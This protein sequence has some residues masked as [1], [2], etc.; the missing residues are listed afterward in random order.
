[1]LEK[2]NR[3]RS[4][5]HE[6]KIRTTRTQDDK[7][8]SK[9]GPKRRQKKNGVRGTKTI[10]ATK[11]KIRATR[12]DGI[13]VEEKERR[14]QKKVLKEIMKR[15]NDGH[16]RQ[17]IKS[18][19]QPRPSQLSPTKQ[20]KNFAKAMAKREKKDTGKNCM[21]QKVKGNKN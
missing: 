3:R 8:R 2:A 13:S 17:K 15:Q 9:E 5:K 18:N 12:G 11:K 19:K 7:E 20:V 14:Q 1:M 10:K 21:A 4:K 6:S 16:L